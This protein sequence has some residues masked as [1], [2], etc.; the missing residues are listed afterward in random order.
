MLTGEQAHGLYEWLT[1]KLTTLEVNTFLMRSDQT[2]V[3]VTANNV[4]ATV[5][6]SV[7]LPHGF[8]LLWARLGHLC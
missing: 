3:F 8:L 1:A 2:A 6:C 5:V 7:Y 4:P